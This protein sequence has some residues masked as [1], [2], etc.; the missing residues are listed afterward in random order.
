MSMMKCPECGKEISDSAKACPN[1]GYPIKQK[2]SKLIIVFAVIMGI[3]ALVVLASG[4][5]DLLS[6]RQEVA[7]AENIPMLGN[8][9]MGMSGYH[10]YVVRFNDDN[11][12]EFVDSGLG[13]EQDE[14]QKAY[15]TY[16]VD[17]SAVEITLSAGDKMNCIIHDNGK[18]LTIEGET[19][20]I[21]NEDE[22]SQKTMDC[23]D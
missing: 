14:R 15:G 12:V 10:V 3:I 5:K 20:S 1:C 17:K 22:V 7:E 8:Y 4:I 18:E 21:V 13:R 11:T 2:K 6:A 9:Y 19:F 23:F 16:S